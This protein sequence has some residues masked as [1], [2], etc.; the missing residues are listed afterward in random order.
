MTEP[1]RLHL[2]LLVALLVS[3]C[4]GSPSAA[5]GASSPSASPAASA[6]TPGCNLVPGSLVT[7]QLGIAVGNPKVTSNPL[8]TT[9]AY[10]VGANP[11]GVLIRFQIH[12]NH[13]SFVDGKSKFNT[14]TDVSSVGDEAY[15]SV[16]ASYTALVARKGTVEI[17]ITSKASL[18]AER[19]LMLMLLAEV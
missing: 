15:Y 4:G 6:T 5:P 1:A 19:R 8:V 9:C 2:A 12:E 17:E 16:L 3:S 18:T 14:T 10:A 11:S 7:A 13:A